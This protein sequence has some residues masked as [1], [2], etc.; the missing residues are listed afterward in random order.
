MKYY[1]NQIVKIKN[2]NST[3]NGKEVR[4]KGVSQ[5]SFNCIFYIVEFIDK[6]EIYEYDCISIVDSCLE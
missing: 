2:A 4:I 6:P 1:N 3:L 5:T